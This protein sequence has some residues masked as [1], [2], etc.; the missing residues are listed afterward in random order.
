V[1]SVPDITRLFVR[2]H[3]WQEGHGKAGGRA[4]AARRADKANKLLDDPHL[5][6][7]AAGLDAGWLLMHRR[8]NRRRDRPELTVFPFGFH[9][10]GGLVRTAIPRSPR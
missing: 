6:K 7:F 9:R 5:H 8:S 2:I 3:K 1:T 10:H 4:E